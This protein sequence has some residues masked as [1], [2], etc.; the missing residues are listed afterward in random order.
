MQLTIKN[1]EGLALMIL[2]RPINE[3]SHLD[4]ETQ[5]KSHNTNI[6]GSPSLCFYLTGFG[7]RVAVVTGGRVNESVRIKSKRP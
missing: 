3:S 6:S 5:T 1:T 4:W 2:Q 7:L